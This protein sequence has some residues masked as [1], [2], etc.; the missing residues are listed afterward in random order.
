M[1]EFLELALRR[2]VVRRA[3]R[4]AALVGTL[5]IA[6]NHGDRILG[7]RVETGD[8]LKMFLTIF[9]PY[10]VS[11]VSSVAALRGQASQGRG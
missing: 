5:L 3:L 7:G 1:G 9:V 6:I 8:L 4:I 11:T 10:G 2:D